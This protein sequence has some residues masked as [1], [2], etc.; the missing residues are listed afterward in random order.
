MKKTYCDYCG[1]KFSRR[2]E[3]VN[4]K[5]CIDYTNYE[6]D[7]GSNFV[8]NREDLCENCLFKIMEFLVN[9]RKK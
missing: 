9:L 1:K 4:G 6:G 3:Y 7:D 8:G 5:L 2:D